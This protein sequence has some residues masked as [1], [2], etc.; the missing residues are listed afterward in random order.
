MCV[1]G[2]CQSESFSRHY[3]PW[4]QLQGK[5]VEI[6]GGGR[7]RECA[8]IFSSWSMHFLTGMSAVPLRV[9]Q[10]RDTLVQ[11]A[12]SGSIQPC[13]SPSETVL[14]DSAVGSDGAC[15]QVDKMIQT[16][17]EAQRKLTHMLA[18]PE[19]T[20]SVCVCT[21]APT[22]VTRNITHVCPCSTVE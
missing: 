6:G 1:L 2:G 9:V 19:L 5:C 7:V 15:S 18:V 8:S 17:Q 22:N 10:L 16:V 21:C 20:V 11:T 3:L 4:W 13:A 12:L 14:V